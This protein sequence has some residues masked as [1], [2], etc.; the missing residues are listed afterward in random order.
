[1]AV[2]FVVASAPRVLHAEVGCAVLVLGQS[3][4]HHAVVVGRLV[5][6]ERLLAQ[7][8][9]DALLRHWSREVVDQLVALALVHLLPL[10]ALGVCHLG[11]VA[12]RHD[13][14]A[15][16]AG[17][18]LLADIARPNDS[19]ARPNR[20]LDHLGHR[21]HRNVPIARPGPVVGH[22]KNELF[23]E[24]VVRERAEEHVV[25][26]VDADDLVGKGARRV[27]APLPFE[28][29]GYD[30]QVGVQDALET[31]EPRRRELAILVLDDAIEVGLQ[32]LV[33]FTVRVHVGAVVEPGVGVLG[34]RP[35]LLEHVEVVVYRTA[36]TEVAAAVHA[37]VTLGLL[38]VAHPHHEH[39][40]QI[41]RR[42]AHAQHL[43]FDKAARGV[44][45]ARAGPLLVG[46][47]GGEDVTLRGEAVAL[48]L[49]LLRVLSAD[50]GGEQQAKQ[51]E[52]CRV[53]S[54]DSIQMVSTPYR[55]SATQVA[56]PPLRDGVRGCRVHARAG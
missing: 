11:Q 28:R 47:G 37:H 39:L 17:K 1:M 21:L 50:A 53:L 12:F 30:A 13:R 20:L 7:F 2:V 36:T 4:D 54:H 19:V 6:V 3:G 49:L 29:V 14:D 16:L 56:A 41:H 24:R 27:V 51:E 25:P 42:L 9:G 5:V 44:A 8:L 52:P 18:A 23:I 31:L 35:V 45:P 34:H 33:E 15:V 40:R 22:L 26:R 48:G 10:Q 43:C 32:H 46:H 38:L 55:R